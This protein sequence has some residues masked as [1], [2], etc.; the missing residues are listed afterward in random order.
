MSTLRLYKQALDNALR[1][2][3]LK[4][5]FERSD[6]RKA[7]AAEIHTKQYEETEDELTVVLQP[8]FVE[9]VES[10][11]TELA[12][13]D[14]PEDRKNLAPISDEAQNL[15]NQSFDPSE[16]KNELIE[17]ALPVIAKKMFEAAHA[18]LRVMGFDRKAIVTW[19]DKHVDQHNKSSHTDEDPYIVPE[20]SGGPDVVRGKPKGPSLVPTIATTATRW[21]DDHP[22]D[23]TK[24]AELM[25]DTG[26]DI[27]I[28]TKLPPSM[29]KEI[30]NQL[31]NTFRQPYWDD[32]SKTTGGDAELSL[33]RGLREGWSIR[34]IAGN[35]RDRFI[36]PNDPK[37]T[38]KYARRRSLNI[39]RTEA[40]N[41]LN[42]ARKAS[43]NALME[44]L[45]GQVPMRAAWLSVLGTTTRDTH[46][47]LDG[48]P[49]DE[50]GLWDL[51]GYKVPWPG[52]TSLP[53]ELRC[54]CQCTINMEFGLRK[55]DAQQLINEY[56]TFRE[57]LGVAKSVCGCGCGEKYQPQPKPVK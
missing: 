43:M 34:K 21:L 35:M 52:H 51:A 22:G 39:A 1:A 47:A 27:G 38:A 41:A 26:M 13:L 54:Q 20:L 49:A 44:E 4:A 23:A 29:Q 42:G 6:L 10:I 28:V 14:V 33:Q 8:M 56:D 30:S 15:I 53:P 45:A 48:V 50:Q 16:W 12:K 32:I 18:Q 5:S 17:R 19:R 37:G 55:E 36:D 31:A 46:A 57:Q 3:E 25:A 24:L 40:G 2:V 7:V 9:Q 11:A